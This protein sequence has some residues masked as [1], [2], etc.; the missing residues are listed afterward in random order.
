M[1]HQTTHPP[2]PH[3]PL[4]AALPPLYG[5]KTFTHLEENAGQR[6]KNCMV[7]D[8][9]HRQHLS[10]NHMCKIGLTLTF[11]QGEH[12]REDVWAEHL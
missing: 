7:E 6:E 9:S 3:L 5:S 10:L 11:V 1:S 12:E 2:P 4:Q 8:S